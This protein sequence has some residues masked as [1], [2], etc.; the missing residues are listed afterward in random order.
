MTLVPFLA[1]VRCPLQPATGGYVINRRNLSQALVALALA[2]LSSPFQKLAAAE[3]DSEP[4]SRAQPGRIQEDG[5]KKWVVYISKRQVPWEPVT[6]LRA[7]R[8][9][10]YFDSNM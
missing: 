5:Q 6:F 3:E 1:T 10:N 7:P 2:E 8:H 4:P 9:T